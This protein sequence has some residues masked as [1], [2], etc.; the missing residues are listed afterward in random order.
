M[1][2]NT[3]WG[4]SQT[5]KTLATGIIS[6]TTAGHGGIY[7]EPLRQSH[8]ARLFPDFAT[9]AGGPW[10]EEDEDWAVVALAFPEAFEDE[11]VYYAVE[12]ATRFRHAE[13]HRW[14]CV[15][16]W[17]ATAAS[18]LVR[19]RANAFAD[20]VKDKWRIGSMSSGTP[21]GVPNNYWQVS[22]YRGKERK[23]AY[24]PYPRERFLSD[25]E[26]N[27]LDG[28]QPEMRGN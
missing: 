27:A 17:L 2:V 9:F 13:S 26:L 6:I 12:A 4:P 5:T 23:T 14:D 25:A 19:K 8:V 20:I 21:D 15:E 24:M 22:L 18:G 1:T 28:V 7:L 3:P 16:S 10:Y 11:A